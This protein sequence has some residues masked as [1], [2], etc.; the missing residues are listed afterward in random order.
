MG[1][2]KMRASFRTVLRKGFSI[3]LAVI[4][5]VLCL[6]IFYLF[7]PHGSHV[8]R[9]TSCVYKYQYINDFNEICNDAVLLSDSD[10]KILRSFINRQRFYYT[11]DYVMGVTADHPIEFTNEYRSVQRIILVYGS[12]YIIRMDRWNMECTLSYEDKAELDQILDK[13]QRFDD[14]LV[15]G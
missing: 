4:C 1:G 13:Y 10:A 2:L 9:I 6:L 5:T 8:G 15:A 14:V 12:G 11:F 3:A 7:F